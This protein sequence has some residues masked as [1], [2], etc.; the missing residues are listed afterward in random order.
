MDTISSLWASLPKSTVCNP[1]PVS[2]SRPP[3]FICQKDSERPSLCAG[4]P[5]ESSAESK[6][7]T[8]ASVLT[9][10]WEHGIETDGLHP[11]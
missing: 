4:F 1:M 3:V 9:A 8:L 5:C 7:L 10:S 6:P 2:V 11:V